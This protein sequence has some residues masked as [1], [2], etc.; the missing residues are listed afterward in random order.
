MQEIV[1]VNA[2]KEKI[3]THAREHAKQS[4]HEVVGW[5]VGFFDADDVFVL[6][7][8]PATQYISQSKYGAE[9]NP[10]EEMNLAMSYPRKIGIV[11]LYHSHPFREDFLEA[12]AGRE[13]HSMFH[14]EIDDHTLSSRASS[15]KNYL[16]VVT[17][18]YSLGCFLYSKKG[19]VMI[20]PKLVESYPYQNRL[21]EYYTKLRFEIKLDGPVSLREAF[22]ESRNQIVEKI[23]NIFMRELKDVEMYPDE[24]FEKCEL[25]LAYA[26][27]TSVKENLM[28][29][30]L[31]REMVIEYSLAFNIVPTIFAD[32]NASALEILNL[33]KEES[34]D[35]CLNLFSKADIEKVR[36]EIKRGCNLVEC[37]FG[38]LVI[39]K[40]GIL[41]KIKYIPP[42]RPICGK[43][44]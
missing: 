12:T 33:C 17:D 13:E 43:K 35:Q 28:K 39:E 4:G 7:A 10:V 42:H 15:K 25:N 36:R 38:E 14:S 19:A 31:D 8:V 27:E 40:T 5:L 16:S 9:A 37:H 2:A 32:R 24:T 34:I 1:M 23:E 11:G 22:F 44:S 41:P 20:P 30:V 21:A 26:S 18:G 6:D 3:L 29:L